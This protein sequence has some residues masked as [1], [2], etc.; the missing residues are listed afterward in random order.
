MRMIAVVVTAM[1]AVPAW[2][3]EMPKPGPEHEVLKHLEGTWDTTLKAGGQESKGT[4]TY[5]ME[6]GGFWLVGAMESAMFGTKFSGK[7]LESY[8]P[9]KRKYVS[10][11]V[12]SMSTAPVTM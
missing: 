4:V 5:K 11:W 7:S 2:S 9:A 6:L 12:D 3:Q 1:M 8:C 10:V